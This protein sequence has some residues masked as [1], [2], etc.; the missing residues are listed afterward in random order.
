MIY[1]AERWSN[2]KIAIILKLKNPHYSKFDRK[3]HV[4]EPNINIVYKHSDLST[5]DANSLKKSYSFIANEILNEETLIKKIFE[6]I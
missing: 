3:Y 1:V 4:T 6:D 5:E 2:E